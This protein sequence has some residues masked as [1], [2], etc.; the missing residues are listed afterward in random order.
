MVL[1]TDRRITSIDES[2]NVLGYRDNV[3]KIFR[4][5]KSQ[6]GVSYWGLASFGSDAMLDR[7]KDFEK[8]KVDSKDDVNVVSEK[9]AGYLEGFTPKIETSMG[10]HVAGYCRNK[11]DMYPQLRHV[12]HVKWHNPGQFTNE[13]SNQEYHLPDGKKCSHKYDPFVAL[14]NGD[15][16]I[17]NALFNFLPEIYPSRKQQII[18]D[19]LSLD[20]SI[21]LARLIIGA[22]ASI[23]D[24]LFTLDQKRPIK[25]V[26]G[27][28]IAKITK[29]EGFEWVEK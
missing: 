20:E 29:N 14:F 2:G 27:V 23:L 19:L 28:M 24:F 17:A 8:T 15:N 3:D 7:L 18:L 10:L 16:T 1:A 21:N 26:R 9:L 12:F 5:S 22:S 13:N 11:G 25:A 6:I 4:F